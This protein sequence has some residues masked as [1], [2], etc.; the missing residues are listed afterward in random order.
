MRSLGIPT[1]RNLH[2]I[3]FIHIHFQLIPE[4][5]TPDAIDSKESRLF[6]Q[7]KLAY[8]VD[9]VKSTTKISKHIRHLNAI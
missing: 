3:L 8:I 6:I 9:I 4:I 1:L 2:N 7:I 5:S